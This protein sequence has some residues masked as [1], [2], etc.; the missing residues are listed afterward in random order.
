MFFTRFESPPGFRLARLRFIVVE[1]DHSSPTSDEVKIT[2]IS[3]TRISVT[4]LLKL[5]QPKFPKKR[6]YESSESYSAAAGDHQMKKLNLKEPP[7]N[8]QDSR[9]MLNQTIC[10]M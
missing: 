2:W 4:L 1:A 9:R 10:E 5:K 6:A 7:R 8:V 3:Y